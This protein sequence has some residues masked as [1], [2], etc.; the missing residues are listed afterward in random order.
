MATGE[1][2]SP[3][4]SGIVWCKDRHPGVRGGFSE[5]VVVGE[6]VLNTRSLAP[7]A[8]SRSKPPSPVEAEEPPMGMPNTARSAFVSAAS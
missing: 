7:P 6:Q 2:R 8:K 3:Q 4:R 5:P 1:Y